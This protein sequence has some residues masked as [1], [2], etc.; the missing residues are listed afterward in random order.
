MPDDPEATQ[1]TLDALSPPARS[2]LLGWGFTI[3]IMLRPGCLGAERV[4][5][6]LT[7]DA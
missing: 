4:F 3:P 1:D 7:D 2:G 5:V 6:R